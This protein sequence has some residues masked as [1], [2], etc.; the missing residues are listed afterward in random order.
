MLKNA[1]NQKM[2]A[3]S[4]NQLFDIPYSCYYKPPLY[5][6]RFASSIQEGLYSRV[7]Y[8]RENREYGMQVFN[9]RFF[10]HCCHYLHSTGSMLEWVTCICTINPRLEVDL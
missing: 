2:D 8:I 7:A 6:F 3:T 9:I 10:I 5:F 1:S 4:K